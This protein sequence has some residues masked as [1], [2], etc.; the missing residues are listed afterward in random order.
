MT[1]EE[2][3]D[4]L[5]NGDYGDEI[6][7]RQERLAKDNRLVVVFGASDDLAEL[8]GAID[9]EVTVYEGSSFLLCKEGIVPSSEEIEE[10]FYVDDPEALSCYI[11][12]KDTAK[13]IE[14]IW[15]TAEYSWIYKTDI[16][17]AAFDVLDGEEKF[18]R[19]IVF[20]LDD[21]PE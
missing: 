18:C 16:P 13:K 1:K 5:N 15:N 12:Y 21:L 8:R 14:A 7:P 10:G 11:K 19:G 3:A 4:M 17:H 9:D 20:S 6:S 2:L